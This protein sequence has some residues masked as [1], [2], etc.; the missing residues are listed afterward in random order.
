MRPLWGE[1]G[2]IGI[3]KLFGERSKSVDMVGPLLVGYRPPTELPLS[4]QVGAPCS[5]Q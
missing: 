4:P 3:R 2:L 1:Q 5:L